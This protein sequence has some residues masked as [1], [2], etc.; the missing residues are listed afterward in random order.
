MK[1]EARGSGVSLVTLLPLCIILRKKTLN[2]NE[3]STL[4]EAPQ[5]G[6]STKAAIPCDAMGRQMATCN[7]NHT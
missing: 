6:M 7:S 1:N 4:W 3:A 5:R 2:S